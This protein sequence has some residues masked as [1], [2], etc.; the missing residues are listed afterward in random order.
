MTS[1]SLPDLRMAH[2]P[3]CPVLPLAEAADR[4]RRMAAPFRGEE[5]RLRVYL[6]ERWPQASL[7]A[8]EW[9]YPPGEAGLFRAEILLWHPASSPEAGH[10]EACGARRTASHAEPLAPWSRRAP[11]VILTEEL[12][13][14]LD[15]RVIK[16]SFLT[17]E[18]VAFGGRGA[19]PGCLSYAP[20]DLLPAEGVLAD[21]R[22]AL[23]EKMVL[24]M[25]LTTAWPLREP[26]PPADFPQAWDVS[27][28]GG[29]A[30]DDWA[31]LLTS[32]AKG[33]ISEAAELLRRMG[34]LPEAV[35][36]LSDWDL[37]QARRRG[38]WPFL[39]VPAPDDEATRRAEQAFREGMKTRLMR[40]SWMSEVSWWRT[41]EGPHQVWDNALVEGRSGEHLVFSFDIMRGVMRVST[42][43][44]RR[45][46]EG[47][48][49][50]K[51][52]YPG[53]PLRLRLAEGI[54]LRPYPLRTE[55]VQPVVDWF[56]EQVLE[57]ARLEA[58]RRL[59]A[60]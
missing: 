50:V 31:D 5:A 46:A 13:E 30:R 1:P 12:G 21:G 35:T 44:P 34:A 48:I 60:P 51:H 52:D 45:C 15:G 59:A 20:E 58:L 10:F 29:L 57:V 22:W 6:E 47:G 16:L 49:R 14:R 55:E 38:A 33:P 28:V 8:G 9:S 27:S 7:R 40:E 36:A 26:R 32:A 24:L 56:A 39:R 42:P 3:W 4:F 43:H 2:L 19:L 41:R 18:E 53:E 23:Q 11:G 37:P 54:C 17:H 25:P